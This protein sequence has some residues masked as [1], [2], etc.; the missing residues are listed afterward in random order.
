MTDKHLVREYPYRIRTY[1]VGSAGKILLF[2]IFN[3]LQDVAHHDANSLGFGMPH[4]L[5][6]G[7]IWVLSRM[8][9]EIDN[10]P[11]LDD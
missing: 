3:L 6:D 11:A 10:Y 4:L 5:A 7:K 1:Q 8:T 9:I 2:Q